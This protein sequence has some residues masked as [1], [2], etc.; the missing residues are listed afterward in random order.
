MLRYLV[1]VKPIFFITREG[2]NFKFDFLPFFFLIFTTDTSF[3]LFI[4]SAFLLDVGKLNLFEFQIHFN[5]ILMSALSILG[6]PLYLNQ[7]SDELFD[8]MKSKDIRFNYNGV[9]INLVSTYHWQN[10]PD[11]RLKILSYTATI[12]GMNSYL[13]S[14]DQPPASI[15]LKQFPLLRSSTSLQTLS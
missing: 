7:E 1:H 6:C 4:A 14:L 5:C 2:S 11:A 9:S 15:I 13:S 3:P 12:N 8:I 10:M